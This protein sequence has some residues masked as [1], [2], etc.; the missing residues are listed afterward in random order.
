[1]MNFKRIVLCAVLSI[2][3]TFSL[4]SC[5]DKDKDKNNSDDFSIS[6]TGAD[7]L[8]SAD[9]FDDATSE[10]LS[11]NSFIGEHFT[12]KY[13]SIGDEYYNRVNGD[14]DRWTELCQTFYDLVVEMGVDPLDTD[15]DLLPDEY[16]N[17][18]TFTDPTLA[19][20]DGDGIDDNVEGWMKTDPLTY[21][22]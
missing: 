5:T 3:C 15:G 6:P 18:K 20:T 9:P 2:F 11:E 4:L 14:L 16:E 13:E 19:D 7:S 12:T 10:E 8:E 1:M 21:D 22:E 17:T